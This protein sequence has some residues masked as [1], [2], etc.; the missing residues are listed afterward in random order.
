MLLILSLIALCV[1]APNGDNN[2][3]DIWVREDGVPMGPG[4]QMD[5]HLPCNDIALWGDG[6]ADATGTFTVD[7]WPPSGTQKT[8]YGPAQWTYNQNPTRKS[9]VQVI[10]VI[11]VKTL[12]ANAIANRDVAA[13]QGFHFKV[14]FVQNPQKHKTFWINCPAPKPVEVPAPAP[15]PTPV[16]RQ[17]AAAAVNVQATAT[18]QQQAATAE[19]AQTVVLE[20]GK[21]FT[22]GPT[23]IIVQHDNVC[24]D[25]KPIKEDLAVL[26]DQLREA[27]ALIQKK[28]GN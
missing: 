20:A 21:T 10:A 9:G 3:G 13:H 14:Q 12:L 28:Y 11:P 27:I 17:E 4:H 18:Q 7:G 26:R 24:A 1:A 19:T 22:T 2:A 6:L 23:T 25:T 8:A 5:P 16:L 15:V